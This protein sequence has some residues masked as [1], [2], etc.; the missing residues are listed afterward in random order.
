MTLDEIKAAVQQG[1]TVHWASDAYNV[2][3]DNIGQWLVHC[4]TNDCYWGLT[5]LDGVT[6]NGTPEQFYVG[7]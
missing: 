1:K 2:I 3:Q 6:V 7:K 4:T 5:H